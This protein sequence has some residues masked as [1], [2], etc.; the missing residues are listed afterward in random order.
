MPRFMFDT[1]IFGKILKMKTPEALLN[2][3]RQ[4]FVTH[5]QQDELEGTP[6]RLRDQ[7][8]SVFQII[9]QQPIPTETAIFD[10][11]R[12]GMAKF[13]DGDLYTTILQQLDRAKPMEHSNNIKDAIIAETAI[14][15]QIVLVTNDKTLAN[16]VQKLGGQVMSFES[17]QGI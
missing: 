15:N 17:T 10:V 3:G 6:K 5:I 14:K 11:S 7:L 12:F 2:G 13:G 16:T 4:Y 1:N 9:P 8:L